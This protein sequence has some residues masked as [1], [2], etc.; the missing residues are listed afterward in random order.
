MMC[1]QGRLRNCQR[2]ATG[3]QDDTFATFSHILGIIIPIDELIFFRGIDST[4]Q[5]YF[6]HLFTSPMGQVD[7]NYHQCTPTKKDGP[8][9]VYKPS[10]ELE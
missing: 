5:I 3:L 7:K 2:I 9:F 6:S 1:R 10:A 4:N 8:H